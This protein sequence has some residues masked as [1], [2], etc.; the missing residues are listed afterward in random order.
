MTAT[1][2]PGAPTV[3]TDDGVRLHAQLDAA[4]DRPAAPTLLA[5][6]SLGC[7]LSMWD[8]QLDAWRSTHDVLRFDQRGHGRSEAPRG[9]YDLDRLGRDALAVLD[10]FEIDR[11]DVCGLSLGG[12]VAQW[13]CLEAP[14]RV[15]RTVFANTA[16]RVGT[17]EAW[18]ER[19][20]LVRDE[21]MAAVTEPVLERFF[22]PA[23][24]AAGGPPVT[25][26]RATLA[27]MAPE[28][29]ASCCEA[30]AD[31]DLRP[32]LSTI[33]HDCLVVVG[34]ADVATPP[35]DARAL[36][37]GLAH[38][39]YAQ[40][41]GAGHLSNLERPDDFARLVHDFLVAAHDR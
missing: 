35:S 13:L 12:L 34:T 10:A 9:P 5:I 25:G 40:L 30:L 11:A 7:D 27:A 17:R 36:V 19:A 16:A 6:N 29:Y 38:A 41:D 15:G 3:T 32:R 14:E 2:E 23:A 28:G 22:S 8:G 33:D 18:L 1:H 21:G 24:L 26:T 20:A 31:A 4:G 39:T 37:A